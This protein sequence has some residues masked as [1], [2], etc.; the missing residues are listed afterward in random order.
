MKYFFTSEVVCEGHPDMVCDKFSDY[1]LDEALRQDKNSKM[2]VEVTIKNN[3]VVVYG[4]ANTK[5]SLD[6]KGLV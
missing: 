6:Y 5:A 4:E 3:T 2:T 1:I